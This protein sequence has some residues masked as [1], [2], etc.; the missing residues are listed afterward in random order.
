MTKI[1]YYDASPIE[2]HF[3][4]EQLRRIA[5]EISAPTC[6]VGC[7]IN[8]RVGGD[9]AYCVCPCHSTQPAIPPSRI[10]T[11][12]HI[13]ETGDRCRECGSTE[14]GSCFYCKMD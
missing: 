4:G 8:S 3:T 1:S 12:R 7:V 10:R 6:T 11:E 5:A 9:H 13:E 2:G 14:A